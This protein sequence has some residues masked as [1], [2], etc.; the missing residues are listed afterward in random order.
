MPNKDQLTKLAILIALTGLFIILLLQTPVGLIAL[1]IVTY[2][3]IACAIV[4][5]A[6]NFI[7]SGNEH[8]TN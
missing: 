8:G 5:L 6:I 2:V 3:I 1:Q 4:V 7:R